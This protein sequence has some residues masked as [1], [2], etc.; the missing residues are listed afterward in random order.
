MN[1]LK[2]I[3]TNV[4]F[5]SLYG[6]AANTSGIVSIGGGAYMVSRSEKGFDTTGS[7]VKAA[8]LKEAIDFCLLTGKP[9]EIITAT[10]K[11]MV[12]FTSD[13]QAEVQFKCVASK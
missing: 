7:R 2:L 6:C 11:D 3:T 1:L 5:I 10:Q 9:I 12:P 4:I 13:A 8:T